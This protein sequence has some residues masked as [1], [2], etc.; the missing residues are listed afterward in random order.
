M[1]ILDRF[2]NYVK[3]P[4]FS[5][6][7]SKLNPSTKEQ[8]NLAKLLFKELQELGLEVYFD[9]KHCYVYAYLKGNIDAPKLGFIAHMDTS[10]DAKGDEINPQII[11]NYVG[12]DI[13]I[14]SN[15]IKVKDNPEL[16]KHIGKTIITS[17]GKTLLGADDKAGIAEI[18][19]MLDYFISS[20]ES[21]GDIYVAFSPDE[22]IG[23]GTEFFD[24][25]KFK[26]DFAYTVD[27]KELGEITYE[28]F[29]AATVEISINGV[30]CHY[31]YAKDKMINSILIANQ[32]INL[33]PNETPANTEGY[34]GYYHLDKI[35]GSVVNTT[36]K[37]LIRD[38]ERNSFEMRKNKF[39][40]IIKVFNE[41]Y[42]NC[43]SLKITDYYYNMK[44]VI[45]KN[46][47]LIDNAVKVMI[48]NEV[49]RISEPI[50][51]G[52]DGAALA[53]KGLACPNLGTGGY[54]FHSIYEYIT[55]EDMS[56]VTE[57]LIGLV[58]E[59]AKDR[60]TIKLTKL[61]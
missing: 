58:K 24:F 60:D 36:I 6:S 47:H 29:N 3:I 55:L 34:E 21:H 4:T 12:N 59:Y 46:K 57:I 54:N 32:I 13:I 56:K 40:S 1:N 26:A 44:E 39:K 41:T 17:D 28:N 5:D 16:K 48:E 31:G 15:V 7:E 52:T 33:I 53:E 51:G 49:E 22:E 14:G 61:K 43:I 23:K 8:F 27:G 38:F 37:Y 25:S 20:N 35:E 50:R 30:T 19:T 2:L 45:D 10:E 42:N 11:N 18:M 9:E